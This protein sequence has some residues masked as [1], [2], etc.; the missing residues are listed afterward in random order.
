LLDQEFDRDPH[1]LD[2]HR[3]AAAGTPS[4]LSSG[5]P[6]VNCTDSAVGDRTGAALGATSLP[7][8]RMAATLETSGRHGAEATARAMEL[9]EQV[10]TFL[11]SGRTALSLT[12]RGAMAGRV[13]VQRV[14]AGTVSLRFESK[15]PPAASELAAMQSEL[16]RRGLTV[17]AMDV[18]SVTSRGD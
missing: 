16:Q 1:R 2:A 3:P 11:R 18:V 9:V 5:A 7:S 14:A 12:L 17:R 10:E 8:E 15:R 4:S 6:Q 13:E